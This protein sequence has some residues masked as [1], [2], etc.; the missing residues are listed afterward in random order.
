MELG[1]SFSQMRRRVSSGLW[2]VLDQG[3][4]AL[5][6][7]RETWHRAVMAAVLSKNRAVAS[8][9]TAGHLHGLP[10]CWKTTP[11]ITVPFTGNARSPLATVRRRSDFEALDRALVAGIPVSSVAETLFDLARRWRRPRLERAI[12]H[13]LVRAMVSADELNT[14]LDRVNGSRLK[15][16]VVFRGAIAE[17]SDDYVPTESQLEH[18]LFDVLNEPDIP[19]IERQ[20]SL[21]WWEQL[22]HRVDGLIVSWRLILEAD[23]RTFHSKRDDFE[24]D[25]QRDNLAAAHGYRVMR[26]TH[27]MLT[28]DPDEVLRLVREAGRVAVG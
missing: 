19:T 24:R 26:F 2:V 17:L 3:T 10:D 9:F 15:G 5:D 27:Q 8:G 20:V 28:D 1:A 16:T 22:P 25:R 18:L 4:Y 14:V 13:A 12:D 21:D 23:G 6:S 7:S 11:E